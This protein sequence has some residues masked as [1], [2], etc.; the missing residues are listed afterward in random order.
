M[1]LRSILAVVSITALAGCYY[2][3][4]VPTPSSSSTAPSSATGGSTPRVPPDI[5][6]VDTATSTKP[7]A[8]YT[9]ITGTSCSNTAVAGPNSVTAVTPTA[10]KLGTT[11]HVFAGHPRILHFDVHAGG[12]D[13]VVEEGNGNDVIVT[14][15]I[16]EVAISAGNKP[17]QNP[18]TIV[19][20]AIGNG[21]IT[22]LSSCPHEFCNTSSYR[23][24]LPSRA[25][26][27]NG[28]LQFGA[29]NVED[30]AT[31]DVNVITD[32]GA[33]DVS[34]EVEGVRIR[35]ATGD[36]TVALSDGEVV[37]L[38]PEVGNIQVDGVISQ[39][40]CA[41]TG[42]GSITI[43]NAE[44]DLI[45]GLT[46]GS[47]VSIHTV[48]SPTQLEAETGAGQLLVEVPKGSYDVDASVW[49]L[50]TL[51]IA[52][53]TDDP[54]SPYDLRAHSAVGDVTIIGL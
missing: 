25:H 9:T 1:H 50:G 12:I 5:Q 49:P 37:D 4:S 28:R 19:T 32:I 36:I 20:N 23:V 30:A 16:E 26:E 3:I 2:E 21:V 29:V 34:G 42:G 15:T 44:S 45:Y 35:T 24:E 13:V 27:V 41:K 52:G 40:L 51:T 48:T 53:I 47:D 31:N 14:Q 38:V 7:L 11:Q 46:T 6:T 54:K 8:T 33:V 17:L 18:E 22:I 10:T 43:T 39:E